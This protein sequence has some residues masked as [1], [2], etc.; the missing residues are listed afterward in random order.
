VQT[1]VNYNFTHVFTL[2]FDGELR[3][4]AIGT[5]YALYCVSPQPGAQHRRN[6]MTR[7]NFEIVR[8]YVAAIAITAFST[9]MLAIIS[10]APAAG[11]GSMGVI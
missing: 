3:L 7:I 6:T 4:N 9:T 10:V 1:T 2:F 11:S 5:L 8:S